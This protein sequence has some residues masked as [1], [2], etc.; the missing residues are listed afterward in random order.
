VLGSLGGQ[1]VPASAV[2]LI[3]A[4]L[5]RFGE[6]VCPL[7]LGAEPVSFTAGVFGLLFGPVNPP[8]CN[9]PS[10]CRFFDRQVTG[11]VRRLDRFACCL[12]LLGQDP[13]AICLDAFLVLG[14]VGEGLSHSLLRVDTGLLRCGL[15][16]RCRLL[17]AGD[18]DRGIR[19][20]LLRPLYRVLGDRIS[21]S[22]LHSEVL[23]LSLG[24]ARYPLGGGLL[25]LCLINELTSRPVSVI[26]L[27]GRG[28][29]ITDRS[30]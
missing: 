7:Q 10:L 11:L 27:G 13:I 12:C 22:P 20:D 28:I 2:L 19:L 26:H 1:F 6:A 25:S 23:D 14:R 3:G 4:G 15:S 8:I 16:C 29:Q 9:Q 30:E 5:R 17:G 24:I 21:V 18:P